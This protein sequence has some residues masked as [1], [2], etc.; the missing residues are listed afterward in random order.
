MRQR[1]FGQ[2]FNPSEDDF[3]DFFFH[4]PF[5]RQRSPQRKS[6]QPVQGSGF[7]V[8]SD[9]YILTNN[10]LVGEAED[11]KVKLAD[12]REFEAKVIG[13]D[14]DTEV[15]VIKIEAGNVMVKI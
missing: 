9:G 13:T 1:P 7:I 4:R 12:G 8:S 15:A 14:P 2:P 11:V 3:F 10:H 6:H 5:P